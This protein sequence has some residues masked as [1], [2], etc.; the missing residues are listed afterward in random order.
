MPL[1]HRAA[2]N[3]QIRCA[4]GF[5]AEKERK[6]SLKRDKM[7]RQALPKTEQA[8]HMTKRNVAVQMTAMHL[9]TQSAH[10]SPVTASPGRIRKA[11]SSAIGLGAES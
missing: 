9:A 10:I 3:S 7:V 1:T 2:V 6:A 5:C 11:G 8:G 4:P